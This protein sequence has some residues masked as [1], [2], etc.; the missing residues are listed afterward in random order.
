[1]QKDTLPLTL[2]L[3]EGWLAGTETTAGETIDKLD[4]LLTILEATR[5]TAQTKV[6]D[7]TAALLGGKELLDYGTD[8]SVGQQIEQLQAEINELEVE[9]QRQRMSKED[10][11]HEQNVTQENYLTLVRKADEVQILSQLTGVE[12]QIAA[13]AQPP[14]KPASPRPL[15]TT[16]L[17]IAAGGLA[18]LALAFLLEFLRAER[19]DQA[20][21]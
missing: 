6:A 19:A 21:S 7:L 13:T 2:E 17:G 16:A 15:L 1:V 14:A 18:G 8:G 9:L 4:H 5:A 10:L 20:A 12:V 3:R 11:V